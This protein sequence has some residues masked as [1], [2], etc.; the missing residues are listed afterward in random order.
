YVYENLDTG[1]MQGMCDIL[2]PILIIDNELKQF[3]DQEDNS[4]RLY[5]SYRWFLLDFKRE[6]SYEGVFNVWETIWSAACI[7]TPHFTHFFALSLVQ[8]Y[9]EIIIYNQMNYTDLIKFFNGKMAE[10]HDY[11]AILNLAKEHVRKICEL[12]ENECES[13]QE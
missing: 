9:R 12:Y 4:M 2:A 5:F 7:C 1:Y 11:I 13:A 8:Y 3:L 6:L 10:K